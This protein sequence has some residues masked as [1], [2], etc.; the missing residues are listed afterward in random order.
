MALVRHNELMRDRYI[1]ASELKNFAF[2]HRAWF[3]ERQVRESSFDRRART[4]RSRDAR[5]RR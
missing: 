1:Q 5:P 4:R 2:C 3:L